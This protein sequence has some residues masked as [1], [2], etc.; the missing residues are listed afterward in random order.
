MPEERVKPGTLGPGQHWEAG[1]PQ[2]GGVVVVVKGLQFKVADLGTASPRPPILVI[3]PQVV[4][5]SNPHGVGTVKEGRAD[6]SRFPC[7]VGVVTQL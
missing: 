2:G 6:L 7:V 5:R 1:K 3:L 4:S